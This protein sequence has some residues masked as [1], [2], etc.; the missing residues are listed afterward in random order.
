MDSR[1]TPHVSPRHITNVK[2]DPRTFFSHGDAW[3]Y[4]RRVI[5]YARREIVVLVLLVLIAGAAFIF[6]ELASEV[7]EGDTAAFDR[8]VLNAL[9]VEGQPGDP[10][11]P[12]WLEDM[13]R[14]I[15]SLGGIAIL[16]LVTLISAVYLLLTRKAGA[17]L[18]IVTAVIGGSLLSS[19]LKALFER[20]RPDAIYQAVPVFSASFPSGHAT[21]SAVTYLTLG[22]LLMRVQERRRAKVFVMGTAVTLTMLVGLTRVYFGVRWTTDVLA[23]WTLGAAWAAGAWLVLLLLQRRAGEAEAPPADPQ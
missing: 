23:G 10:V 22:A 11:G 6:V 21:L 19:G 3:R 20:A 17:A 1:L 14:D 2:F 9:R 18:F 12:H 5:D 13:A 7:L 4:G 15:T 16:T 8:A